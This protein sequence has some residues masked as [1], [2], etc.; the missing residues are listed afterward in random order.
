MKVID[1]KKNL[2]ILL[3]QL[4]QLEKTIEQILNN[5]ETV[6]ANRYVS[7]MNIRKH[8][9]DLAIIAKNNGL[10]HGAF[11]T[12]TDIKEEH[13]HFNTFWSTQKATIEGVLIKTRLLISLVEGNLDFV[14][15]EL[16]NLQNFIEISLRQT[17]Y[18]EPKKEKEIQNAIEILFMGRGYKKGIEYERESGKFVF[19]GK[20]YI[21]D[22]IF[23]RYSLAIEV[24]LLKE[25]K[26]ISAIIEEINADITAYKKEYENIMFVIYDIGKV[27]NETEFKRDLENTNNVKIIIVKH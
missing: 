3:L 1:S 20:E 26:S 17:I 7:F 14:D 27:R 23:P 21:P 4:K 9:N 25:N 16:K 8:Y 18:E 11:Y 10:D 19:S 24:K 22:F 13:N 15:D 2:K 5:K 6:E 12:Y